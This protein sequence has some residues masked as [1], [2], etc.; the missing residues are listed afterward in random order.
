MFV[1]TD[2]SEARLN[3]LDFS[4]SGRLKIVP[5]KSRHNGRATKRQ[6]FVCPTRQKDIWEFPTEVGL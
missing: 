2:Y 3:A 4:L 1:D 6:F 5:N